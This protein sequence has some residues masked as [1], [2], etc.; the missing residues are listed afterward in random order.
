MLSNSTIKTRIILVLLMAC[1][2]AVGLGA[3]NLYFRGNT[4]SL[5]QRSA[6]VKEVISLLDQATVWQENFLR[7]NQESSAQKA[8]D[9]MDQA[10][11][12]LSRLNADDNDSQKLQQALAQYQDLFG[13]V[14]KQTKDMQQKMVQQNSQAISNAGLV[15]EKII[16]KVENNKSMAIIRAEDPDPNEDSLLG[17]AHV[18]LENTE[19]LQLTLSR[20]IIGQDMAAFQEQRASA[21]KELTQTLDNLNSILPSITDQELSATGGGLRGLMDQ[22]SASIDQ[23][24]GIWQARKNLED[25]LAALSASVD[26]GAHDYETR[27]QADLK[28]ADGRLTTLSLGAIA[29]TVVIVLLIGMLVSRSITSVLAGVIEGMV[30]S[31][32]ELKTASQQVSNASRSLAEGSGEQASSLEETSS[33]LEEMASMT[34]QNAESAGQAQAGSENAKLVLEKAVVVMGQLTEAMQKMLAASSETRKIVKSIDEIAFQ[35]NLLALNAAVE[36]ARAGEAGAGFAVVADEVRSLAMRAAEAASSTG[37][38]IDDS[39]ANIQNGNKLVEQ[40]NQAIKDVADES[41]KSNVLV[42][43]IATASEEQA[44]GIDQINR[45]VNEIDRVTQQVAASAQETSAASEDLESQAKGI[46]ELVYKLSLLAGVKLNH[47][48]EEYVQDQVTR[49]VALIEG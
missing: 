34:K 1:A 17:I 5:Y 14:E 2:A 48:T 10:G 47:E 28:S 9:Y 26:A 6:G 27:I 37:Q 8:R 18:I 15:R 11:K 42:S 20:L 24:A 30:T 21:Q 39:I 7:T 40:T 4:A 3:I 36:A 12:S 33:S 49:P 38:L 45:A 32:D 29:V 25:Q 35:T 16:S 46:N 31:S 13:Q 43:E 19:R 23:V 44:R 22:F 41:G